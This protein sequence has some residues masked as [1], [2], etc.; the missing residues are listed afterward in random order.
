MEV[1]LLKQKQVTHLKTG[2]TYYVLGNAVN[3]TNVLDGQKMVLYT[4]GVALF[5]R[6][7]EE[8]WNKFEVKHD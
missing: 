2:K 4:D 1:E 3:C 5:V 8:F 6:E 7:K